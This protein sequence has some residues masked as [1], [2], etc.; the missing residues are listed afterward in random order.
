MG[1]WLSM[2]MIAIGVALMVWAYR[3]SAR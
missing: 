1:Q 2:P 3:P